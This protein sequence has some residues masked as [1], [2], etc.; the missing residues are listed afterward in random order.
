MRPHCFHALASVQDLIPP[1]DLGSLCSQSGCDLAPSSAQIHPAPTPAMTR[2]QDSAYPRCVP[3]L[4]SGQDSAHACSAAVPAVTCF[5]DSVHAHCAP[6]L[7]ATWLVSDSVLHSLQYR[8][9][10]QNG[11]SLLFHFVVFR[12]DERLIDIENI[13][14]LKTERTADA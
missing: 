9:D 13:D 10:K 12:L 5:R 6:T 1:A 3:T 14:E 7:A 8:P 11:L 4:G 2:F